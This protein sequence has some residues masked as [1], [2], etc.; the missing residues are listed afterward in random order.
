[1]SEKE[2]EFCPYC[3]AVK[4]KIVACYDG[5]FFCKECSSFFKIEQK[6][7]ECQKC[8][9]TNV[10]DSDFPSPSGEMVFQCAKCKKMYSAKDFFEYNK[11]KGKI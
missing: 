4:H 3:S 1:M 10:D 5:I 7:L 6:F 11:K 8:K 2:L 9:G